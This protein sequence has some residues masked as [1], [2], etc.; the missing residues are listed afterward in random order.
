MGEENNKKEPLLESLVIAQPESSR[1][2][3]NKAF[4]YLS[5]GMRILGRFALLFS[6]F[7]FFVCVLAHFSRYHPFRLHSLNPEV[8]NIASISFLGVFIDIFSWACY[9]GRQSKECV[10]CCLFWKTKLTNFIL[11]LMA[12]VLIVKFEISGAGCVY[13]EFN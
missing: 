2:P 8:D 1:K 12:L 13:G 11:L 4:K 6:D 5:K 7:V 10:P 9:C 3:G